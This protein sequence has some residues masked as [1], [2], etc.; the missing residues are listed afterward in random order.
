VSQD[1]AFR[2]PAGWYPDPL[3]LPQLRWW[4][5]IGWTEQVSIA[6]ESAHA[7]MQT[8]AHAPM[9]TSTQAPVQEARFA[10]MED[11]APVRPQAATVSTPPQAQAPVGMTLNQLEAPRTPALPAYWDED[12]M[13]LPV[14]SVNP[15]ELKFWSGTKPADVRRLAREQAERDAAL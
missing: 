13:S 7:P 12:D 8:S 1:N 15:A 10:W 3:G 5:N 14:P 9:Q 6:P 4:N 11:E 2:A